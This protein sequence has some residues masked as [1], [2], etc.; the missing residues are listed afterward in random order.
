MFLHT[1]LTGLQNESIRNYLLPYLQQQACSVE[2]LL[3]KLNVACANETER[4][5]K[6]RQVM[7]QRPATVHSTQSDEQITEKR[8]K[9]LNRDNSSKAQPDV[10][11]LKNYVQTWHY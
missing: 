3:E 10:M 6:R 11:N 8:N 5:N 4:Q 2:L 9:E 1:V 7:Q